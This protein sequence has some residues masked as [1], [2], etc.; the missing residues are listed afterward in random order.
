M[1]AEVSL[2]QKSRVSILSITTYSFLQASG[3]IGPTRYDVELKRSY[4]S[5]SLKA[6]FA[7]V[8]M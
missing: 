3:P 6:V 2:N 4:R 5:V 1:R 8:R 7:A